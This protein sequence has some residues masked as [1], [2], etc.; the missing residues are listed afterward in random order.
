M[1]LAY[2]LL[3]GSYF[4]FPVGVNIPAGRLFIPSHSWQKLK[5][6]QVK[7]KR[8]K[9][10]KKRQVVFI[11]KKAP[12]KIHLHNGKT[13][14]RCNSSPD[15]MGITGKFEPCFQT[16]FSISKM[17]C[18]SRYSSTRDWMTREYHTS[19]DV[20]VAR[21]LARDEMQSLPFGVWYWLRRIWRFYRF[22]FFFSSTKW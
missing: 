14:P 15:I 12:G 7:E 17:K 21:A 18:R 4:L 16:W 20:R 19:D 5:S 9:K 10:K 6:L 11:G 22:I 13:Y 3:Q 8:K 1:L 2:W